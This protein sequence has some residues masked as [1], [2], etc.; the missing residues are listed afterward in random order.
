MTNSCRVGLLSTVDQPLLPFYL[1]AILSQKIS[2]IVVICDSKKTI[3]EKD[4]KFGKKE[5]VELLKE[6]MMVKRRFIKW[7]KSEYRFIL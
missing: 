3:S 1:A 2:N 4:K 5:Q 6:L 7:R